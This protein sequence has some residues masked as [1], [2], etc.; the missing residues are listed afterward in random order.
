MI[1]IILWQVLGLV[2][3]YITGCVWLSLYYETKRMKEEE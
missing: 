2:T 1:D 3:G